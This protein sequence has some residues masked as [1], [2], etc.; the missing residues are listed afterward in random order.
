M[1][2]RRNRANRMM[3]T[4]VIMF[5]VTWAPLNIVNNIR[6]FNLYQYLL[7]QAAYSAVFA[8]CHCVAMTSVIVNPI[9]YSFYNDTFRNAIL[10]LLPEFCV[11]L[12]THHNEC[13]DNNGINES[14][15]KMTTRPMGAERL[16]TPPK[17][18]K[19]GSPKTMLVIQE[20]NG[21]VEIHEETESTA[22]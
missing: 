6:D 7:P 15:S 18:L 19:N 1:V 9:A 16:V 3:A 4:M 22:L 12:L 14:P 5:A 10:Q 2:E 8:F 21:E 11:K 13:E 17:V 20:V